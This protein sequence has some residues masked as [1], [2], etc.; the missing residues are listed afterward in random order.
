MP[1][2]EFKR[3]RM[4]N[5]DELKDFYYTDPTPF[6]EKE[7]RNIKNLAKNIKYKYVKPT[8]KNSRFEID[9]G[10]NNKRITFKKNF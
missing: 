3:D 10:R 4:S 9:I 5:D 7:A 2:Y 1:N 6:K 8:G